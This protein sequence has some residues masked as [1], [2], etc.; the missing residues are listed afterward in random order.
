MHG[1]ETIGLCG[2]QRWWAHQLRVGGFHVPLCRNLV[3]I[4]IMPTLPSLLSMQP[5]LQPNPKGH[6]LAWVCYLWR[7][8]ELPSKG[9]KL[10]SSSEYSSKLETHSNCQAAGLSYVLFLCWFCLLALFAACSVF[11]FVS[12]NKFWTP[13]QCPIPHTCTCSLNSS[14]SKK[15]GWVEAFQGPN[16]GGLFSDEIK[17]SMSPG[18]W[19]YLV[20]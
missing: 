16:F 6:P 19:S 14:F 8:E 3:L 10:Q 17:F 12:F 4:K 1:S 15:L 7:H 5:S 9:S 20:F 11:V 2:Y 18:L 13:A